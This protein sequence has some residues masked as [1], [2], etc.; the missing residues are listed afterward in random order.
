M[1]CARLGRWGGLSDYSICPRVM[2]PVWGVAARSPR[3]CMPITIT[4]YCHYGYGPLPIYLI[5]ICILLYLLYIN[6][7][8]SPPRHVQVYLLVISP[9]FEAVGYGEIRDTTAGYS[10]IHTAKNALIR[11]YSCWIQ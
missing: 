3:I 9:V 6:G 7:A 4:R 10:R 1:S 11:K 2:G 5:C 8:R